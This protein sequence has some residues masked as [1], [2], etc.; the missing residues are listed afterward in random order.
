MTTTWT[1][2]AIKERL[3]GTLTRFEPEYGRVITVTVPYDYIPKHQAGGRQIGDE[4]ERSERWT[5]EE[6]TILLELRY[7]RRSFD[8]IAAVLNRSEDGC[9]KRYRVIRVRAGR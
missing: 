8:E 1:E 9:M 3:D 7:R 2:A 5:R 4:P 6:D